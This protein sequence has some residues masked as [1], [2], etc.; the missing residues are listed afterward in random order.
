MKSARPTVLFQLSLATREGA[1]LASYSADGL[2]RLEFPARRPAI[3]RFSSSARPNE[4]VQEWHRLA[5]GALTS[6]IEGKT[7][8]T[9][10]PLDLSAGTPFQRLVWQ[11]L[12]AIPAGRSSSYA[13]IARGI[14]RPKAVRAVGGA[15]GANPIPVL[16]PC[17]RVL[18]TSGQ[19][20]GFSGGL[21]WKEKLLRGEGIVVDVR[22]P[23]LAVLRIKPAARKSGPLPLDR[24]PAGVS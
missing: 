9:L 24:K 18:A 8:E 20:G 23:P 13:E 22:I 12:L 4:K 5:L 15:C 11:A 10:P 17:H 21:A 1:F 14:G 19:I 2:C 3:P 6:V 7:P 16:V